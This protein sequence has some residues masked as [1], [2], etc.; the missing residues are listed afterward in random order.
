MVIKCTIQQVCEKVSMLR[1]GMLYFSAV[2][3]T[4]TRSERASEIEKEC[5]YEL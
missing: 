5:V 1:C 3:V 2:P 4:L